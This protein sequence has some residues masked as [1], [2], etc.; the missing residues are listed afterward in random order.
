MKILIHIFA[1]NVIA[2]LNQ[3]VV[4]QNANT[5]PYARKHRYPIYNPNGTSK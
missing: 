4:I 3:H 1:L 5:V 2:G